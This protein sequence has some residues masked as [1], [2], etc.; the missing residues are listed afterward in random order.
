MN[1]SWKI[2][3]YNPDRLRNIEI[4]AGIKIGKSGKDQ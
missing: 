1:V 4:M 3:G 2:K